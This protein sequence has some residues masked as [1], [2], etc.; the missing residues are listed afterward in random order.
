VDGFDV[1]GTSL[2]HHNLLRD[3]GGLAD[4]CLLRSLDHLNGPPQR[5]ELVLLPPA[6]AVAERETKGE[7][8]AE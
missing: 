3:M 4:H 5:A 7:D 6:P 8:P 1:I 2:A